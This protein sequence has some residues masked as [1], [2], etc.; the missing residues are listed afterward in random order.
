MLGGSCS[1]LAWKNFDERC[2][3]GHI[4]VKQGLT[5]GDTSMRMAC[6]TCAS[7]SCLS[8]ERRLAAHGYSIIFSLSNILVDPSAHYESNAKNEIGLRF[9]SFLFL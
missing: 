7:S 2:G 4:V 6:K 1:W 8:I 9:R 5:L 3:S